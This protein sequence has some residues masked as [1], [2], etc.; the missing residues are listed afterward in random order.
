MGCVQSRLCCHTSYFDLSVS[1]YAVGHYC[2]SQW[3]CF[4]GD[5]WMSVP[6]DERKSRTVLLDFPLFPFSSLKRTPGTF[7][8]HNTINLSPHTGG[9]LSCSDNSWLGT[10]FVPTLHC[11]VQRDWTQ[12][13]KQRG[14]VSCHLAAIHPTS[15]SPNHW[16]YPLFSKWEIQQ[17]PYQH[18]ARCT[19]GVQGA[20]QPHGSHSPHMD[21]NKWR[22]PLVISTHKGKHK[23]SHGHVYM[24]VC[25]CVQ[26]SVWSD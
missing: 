3:S 10:L 1:L 2:H 22:C 19:R 26:R 12:V 17:S 14:H 4:I 25:A 8:L 18:A 11:Q 16:K 15:Y 6:T 7:P 24:Y 20:V 9:A 23:R 5:P 13:D 21:R